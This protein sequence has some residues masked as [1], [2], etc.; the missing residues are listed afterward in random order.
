MIKTLIVLGTRPE[1]IKL[2]PLI[3]EMKKRRERYEC[4]ILSTG[5]Q[6]EM[7]EST[8]ASLGIAPDRDLRLMRPG[9][10][11]D[12]LL[13]GV[14]RGTREEISSF[15]PDLVIV[16][17]DT[18]S[19]LGGALAAL[20]EEIPVAHIEAGLRTHD[21]YSPFPEEFDRRAIAQIA[22]FHFAPTEEAKEN[23]LA[24][25]IPEDRVFVVG[26]TAADVLRA[27]IRADF[28][29]PLL[30]RAEKEGKKLVLLTAHRRENLGEK[31][32]GIFRGIAS[33]LSGREDVLCVFPMHRNPDVR[34]CAL[35]VFADCPDVILTEP[36][37]PVSFQ[38]LSARA[39]LI[40]TDSGGMQ[41]EAAILGVPA[42]VLRE[43]TERTEGVLSGALTLTGTDE[44]TVASIVR[45]A[46]DGI[47][48][49][50]PG[51]K[52][53]CRAFFHPYGD[54]HTAEK[55]PDVLEKEYPGNTGKH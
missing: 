8:L 36:L 4:R 25:G 53:L 13:R 28:S 37:D 20:L 16:H 33:A 55:I 2:S 54:G 6:K 35:A 50:K 19:A 31:M 9:Q 47:S 30:S 34:E 1:A 23:L 41:E 7:L 27:N 26:N 21:F 46:L 44:N 43:C 15:R 29:H 3:G 11:L 48:P 39:D 45:Q 10:Q 22:S 14:I 49:A 5:Q 38:N 40:L 52:R 24:E 17:G 18:V 12:G 51:E 32:N 42:L